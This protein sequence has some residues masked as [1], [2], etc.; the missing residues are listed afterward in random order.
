MEMQ[1]VANNTIVV[2]VSFAAAAFGFMFGISV[3]DLMKKIM[4]G[5]R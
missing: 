3:F 2:F 1:E 5:K 4:S